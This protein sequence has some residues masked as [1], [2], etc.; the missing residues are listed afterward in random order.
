MS[1]NFFKLNF[2]LV[3]IW[4]LTGIWRRRIFPDNSWHKCSSDWNTWT[5]LLGDHCWRCLIIAKWRWRRKTKKIHFKSIFITFDI[6]CFFSLYPLFFKRKFKKSEMLSS[7]I[8]WRVPRNLRELK[9]W[10]QYSS[11]TEKVYDDILLNRPQIWENVSK[12]QTNWY[13]KTGGGNNQLLDK[14]PIFKW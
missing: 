12:A 5:W 1:F 3:W 14:F 11:T 10:T 2:I 13:Y 9:T 8:L 6:I 7:D 4:M